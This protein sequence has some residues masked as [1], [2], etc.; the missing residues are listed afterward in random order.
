MAIVDMILQELDKL[1]HN[2]LLLYMWYLQYVLSIV[3]MY[4][5]VISLLTYVLLLFLSVCV[6]GEIVLL[7]HAHMMLFTEV[8]SFPPIVQYAYVLCKCVYST[9]CMYIRRHTYGVSSTVV[10]I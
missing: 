7:I 9:V 2:F 10:S 3:R 4:V 5:H 8:I 6:G 1:T